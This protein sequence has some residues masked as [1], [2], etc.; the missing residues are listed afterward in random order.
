MVL[1]SNLL[2]LSVLA[3]RDAG[4]GFEIFAEGELL[5]EAETVGNLLY[6]QIGLQQVF[7]LP[8]G[9]EVYP[10]HGG[11]ARVLMNEG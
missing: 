8:N 6:L 7:G 3:W 1:K 4:V 10:L 11:A 5:R 2:Y 9:E